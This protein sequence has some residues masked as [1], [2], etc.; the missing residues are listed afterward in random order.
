LYS[1]LGLGSTAMDTAYESAINNASIITISIGGNNL[2]QAAKD[3][4]S[5]SGY[6]FNYINDS[7][8]QVGVKDF[9]DQWMPII[10]KIKALNSAAKIIV[11]TVY[12]PCN[13][14]DTALHN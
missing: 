11:T 3:S 2:M 4:S 6:N 1:K 14:T 13:A 8:A 12:N 10:N 5:Y 9:N 7:V